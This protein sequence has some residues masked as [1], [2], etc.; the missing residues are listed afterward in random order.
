MP[1]STRAH[2]VTLLV[3]LIVMTA[4]CGGLVD[5]RTDSTT[6]DANESELLPGLTEEGVTDRYLLLSAHHDA[7]DHKSYRNSRETVTRDETGTVVE[8]ETQ[9]VVAAP[10]GSPARVERTVSGNG[11]ET[12][13]YDHWI[14]P[15][16]P[17]VRT[18]ESGTVTYTPDSTRAIEPAPPIPL[19]EAYDAVETVTVENG[20]DE[21][22]RLEGHTDRLGRYE[23]VSFTLTL[24]EDGHLTAYTL[25]GELTTD[26]DRHFVTEEFTQEITAVEP[27]EPAWLEEG[28]DEIEER[29]N[30][31]TAG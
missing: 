28:R 29:A 4:G 12:V 19:E 13:I 16:L 25:E 15:E 26:G 1:D 23:N 14:D 10:T 11:T 18:N 27:T 7:F 20:S 17:I 30:S 22:Y 21:R 31:S 9:T 5:D 6:N 24:A 3:V 2:T 8:R